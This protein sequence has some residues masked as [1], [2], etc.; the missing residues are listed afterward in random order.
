MKHGKLSTFISK[1][2]YPANTWLRPLDLNYIVIDADGN[3]FY[4][5]KKQKILF[6][7]S[8]DLIKIKFSDLV[9]VTS[10]LDRFS[11]NPTTNTLFFSNGFQSI[12]AKKNTREAKPGDVVYCYDPRLQTLVHSTISSITNDFYG[13]KQLVLGDDNVITKIQSVNYGMRFYV[14]LQEYLNEE[15]TQLDNPIELY[16]ERDLTDYTAD[17]FIGTDRVCGFDYDRKWGF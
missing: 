11:Y 12:F 9:P 16:V 1:V 6:D 8:H 15:T 14:M 5:P 13:N 3:Q 4:N 7:S 17:I 10:I 2:G